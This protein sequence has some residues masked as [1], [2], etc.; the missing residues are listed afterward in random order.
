MKTEA[1]IQLKR[2]LAAVPRRNFDLR[3]WALPR[4]GCG[5]TGCAAGW[6]A[7]D[8]WFQERGFYLASPDSFRVVHTTQELL[9]VPP[10]SRFSLSPTYNSWRGFRALSEFFDIEGEIAEE[11]FS[12]DSYPPDASPGLVIEKIDRLLA[13]PHA[14]DRLPIKGSPSP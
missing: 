4:P 8:P 6:A 14:F 9:A 11:I 3:L 5:T 7:L 1:F 10:D 13:D 12:A 2:V